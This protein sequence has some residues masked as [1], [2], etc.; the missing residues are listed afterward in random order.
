MES[1]K[2][3]EWKRQGSRVYGNGQ[4]YN[5]TNIVTAQSLQNTLNT[6]ENTKATN[7]QIEDTYDRI[8]KQF[9]QI[10]LTL[11]TL[12]EEVQQLE[13]KIECLYK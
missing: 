5:C 12:Q 1:T 11:G 2:M 7:Q 13:E 10:R 6:Y 9:I 3:T 4:S 8:S